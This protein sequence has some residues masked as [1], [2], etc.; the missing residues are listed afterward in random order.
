MPDSDFL[1]SP[2][3]QKMRIKQLE[4]NC[5]WLTDKMD[6]IHSCLC[7]GPRQNGTWQQRAEHAVKAAQLIK[8]ERR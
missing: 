5:K 6:I 8:K 1:D 4:I 3:M 2:E 7:S